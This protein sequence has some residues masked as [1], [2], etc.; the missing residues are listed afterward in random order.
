MCVFVHKRYRKI[1]ILWNVFFFM[2]NVQMLCCWCASEFVPQICCFPIIP[3]SR[4]WFIMDATINSWD[5]NPTST[6]LSPTDMHL[7]IKQGQW[8][9]RTRVSH[10]RAHQ[11]W[12][13]RQ[14]CKEILDYF[15]NCMLWVCVLNVNRLI[16][17]SVTVKVYKGIFWSWR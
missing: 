4:S 16:L 13:R 10:N 11:N 7:R 6:T 12:N 17:Y 2:V 14:L 1:I 15:V 3:H 9:R 8:R 5:H